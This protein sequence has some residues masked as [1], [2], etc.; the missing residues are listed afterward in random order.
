MSSRR[1][2]LIRNEDIHGKSGTGAVAEG[3]EF[4]N[5]WV[6]LTWVSQYSSG[7]WFASIHNLKHLHGHEGKTKVVWIDPPAID[8]VEVVENDK[9]NEN[10]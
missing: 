2:I 9:E 1:F 4:E 10:K 6:S 3:C 5:G 7:T 8:D